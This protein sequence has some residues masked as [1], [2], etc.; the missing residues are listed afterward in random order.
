MCVCVT[1]VMPSSRESDTTDPMPIV[2]DDMVSSEHEVYT[3]DTTSTDDDDFQPFALPD[4]VA[5]PADGPIAGDLPLAVIPAPVP[6]AAY[7]IVDM[8]LDVVANDDVDLFD[9]DPLEDDLEGE[10]L[11]AV[12]DPLLLA[13]A[14]AEEAPI[15]S[16]VP[17]SFGSGASAPSHAQGVQHHSHDTDP[18][19]AS[20]A[21]P[22]PATAPSFEFGH[23]IDDDSDPVS[24]PVLT[25][26]MTLS[27]YI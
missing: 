9:E 16:P 14:P 24:H 7:P 25:Q 21:A 8:P 11:I 26:I 4:V 2:S 23:D 20:S 22:A 1:D 10:A 6:L 3:S 19:M 15:H 18:D 12:G 5:E 17:D 27:S 13:D